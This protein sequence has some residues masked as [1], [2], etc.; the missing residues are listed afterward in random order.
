MIIEEIWLYIAL[1]V[2]V[3]IGIYL[4]FLKSR[5][6]RDAFELRQDLNKITADFAQTQQKYES[7]A[8][9]KNQLEQWAIQQQT[10]Y[11][12]TAERLSERDNQLQRFQQKIEL[13]EQQENE[14]ER[15]I[16]ELK[17]RIGSSQAKAESL[18]EQLQFSQSSLSHKEREN[19]TLFARLNEV[20]NELTELRT[21]LSEKQANFEAQQRNFIEVKQ[22]LNVEFQH[23]AQQILDEKSKRFAETNQSSLDALLKPFKEQIEGFQK[24]VNEVHSE[25]LKG[26]ANLEAEIKRVLQIGVSM[27]EEAQNL[28]SA[29]KGNN[30][31]AGNWGE[32]QLESALQSAGLLAGEHYVAQ[33]SFRDED[34]KR[35]APD[36]VVHLPDQKHLI[37]DSKVS[38]V[39]YY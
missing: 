22:Q 4:F 30:K 11:E 2:C 19:Q 34:G 36:F 31:V 7:L 5:Y 15:Y 16:N 12:S 32:V 23:L 14:L 3:L 38:L 39:A 33:E 35:F 21:T 20:Q 37:I 6:Q 1:A 27:S 26:T 10:R 8:Q 17:E 9:E 13:A 28:T 29:L 18:E 24:R 25:S